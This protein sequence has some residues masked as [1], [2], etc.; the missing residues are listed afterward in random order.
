MEER[1]NHVKECDFCGS[2]ATCLCHECLLYFCENCYKFIHNM[3]KNNS[4]KKENID[5]FVPTELKCLEH[6]KF[7]ITLFCLVEKSK[8]KFF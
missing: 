4:H 1:N 8:I 3:K 6:S 7:P 5:P 2:Y